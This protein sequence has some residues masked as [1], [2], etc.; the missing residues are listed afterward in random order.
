MRKCVFILIAVLVMAGC[1][2]PSAVEQYRAEKHAQDSAALVDQEHTLAYYQVQWEALI[3]QVDS[4]LPLFR[5]EKNE[6]YQDNGFYVVTGKNGLRVMV[7]DDGEGTVLIYR[8]G[9]RIENAE[10][11]AVDRARHLA[12][13][14]ADIKEL[15]RRIQRSSLE[16]QKY[17]K[18]LQ[19]STNNGEVR[20]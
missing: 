15:E 1:N 13:V 5:Y 4:L 7:R 3:P 11:E 12:I 20:K 8:N 19:K 9:K 17:Q 14:M 10:D 18:R 2:K 16:V 6:K